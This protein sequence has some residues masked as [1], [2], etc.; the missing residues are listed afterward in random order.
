MN[1]YRNFG[2]LLESWVTE[3]YSDLHF[4][5]GAGVDRLDSVSRNSV[6]LSNVKSES[7][8]SGF[9]T[10]STT[11]PCH[12]HQCSALTSEESHPVSG[13]TVNDVQ[14][15]SQSPSICSSSSS[16]VSL[17]SVAPKTTCLKVEQSLR[18]TEPP[19]WREP[20]HQTERGPTGPRY[21][22]HTASFP[23][24]YHPTSSRPH[25]RFAHPRRTHS[26][27]SDPIKADLY[28]KRIKYDQ[29]CQPVDSQLEFADGD[30]YRLD[31]LS[32]GL[33]YLEQVCRMLENIAKLQQQNHSLQKEVEILKSQHAEIECVRLH[34]EE[35]SYPDSQSLQILGHED[36]TSGSSRLK[37]PMGFR[38]RSV[39]DTQAVGRHRRARFAR[40]DLIADVLVEEPDDKDPQP[41]NEHKKLSKI[42][43]LKFTSFRRQ[44]TQ[45]SDKESQ[46][47]QP[48]KKT[49]LPNI[50]RSRRMTT[51]L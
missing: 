22:C 8:D 3:G 15:S 51:R 26:Q 32:P 40:D 5:S 17:G 21:R 50:F 9:E 48:K 49:K 23:T 36:P 10:V 12:S 29:H 27:P 13:S 11:S 16:C 24:S 19:S 41:E 20:L 44:G 33:L 46:S 14:P 25:H 34:K 35:I 28:R 4:Q 18:R 31:K 1:L 42:Q 45:Q 39:S 7:E 37:E 38:H 47:V 30:Q 6:P 43:K 2:N